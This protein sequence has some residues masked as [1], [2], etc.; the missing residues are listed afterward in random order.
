MTS[1]TRFHKAAGLIGLVLLWGATPSRAA[2]A[3]Y[4]F[5]GTWVRA[6]R[7]CTPTTIRARTYTAREVISP[8]GRCAIRR[9]ASGS[10]SFELLE[11]CRRGDRPSTV[12]ETVRMIAPDSLTSKR[13]ESRLKIPRQIRYQRCTPANPGP[14]RSTKGPPASEPRPVP[15]ARPVSEPKP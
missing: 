4:P 9:V 3:P 14:P 5:E 1:D 8:R 10:N 2:E 6:E 13:Q 11:E 15:D 12:T 7:T